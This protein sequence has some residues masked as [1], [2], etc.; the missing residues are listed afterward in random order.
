MDITVEQRS[1]ARVGAGLALVTALGLTACAPDD[2]PADFE[3]SEP[4][5]ADQTEEGAGNEG[6]AEDDTAAEDAADGDAQDDQADAGNEDDDLVAENGSSS[7][8]DDSRHPDQ[9]QQTVTYPLPEVDGEMTVG[10]QSLVAGDETLLLSVSFVPEYDEDESMTM[11]ELHQPGGA[12]GHNAYLLPT[13]SDRQNFKQYYVPTPDP[14]SRAQG[15]VGRGAEAWAT[16]VEGFGL[17]PNE[18][19][20][21]WAYFPLP[22]D[23]IDVVDVSVVP[24]APEFQDVEIDWGDAQPGDGSEDNDQGQDADGDS[25]QSQGED[26]AEDGS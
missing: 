18:V 15:W 4:A 19:F 5:S 25:E 9:A 12:S 2:D 8:E 7:A 13:V 23:D 6:P 11:Y 24:G 1:L 17:T 14:S 3:D 16:Q 20:T 22:E 10:L 21:M 26:A